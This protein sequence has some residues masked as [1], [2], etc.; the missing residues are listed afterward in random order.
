MRM[1]LLL[2]GCFESF[3]TLAIFFPK[4]D[5]STV[6]DES[7]MLNHLLLNGADRTYET[8]KE[9][10]FSISIDVVLFCLALSSLTQVADNS[11]DLPDANVLIQISYHGSSRRQEAQRLGRISRAKKVCYLCEKFCICDLI[12]V[13]SCMGSLCREDDLGRISS[14]RFSTVLCLRCD[15][16]RNNNNYNN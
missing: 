5:Y 11:F 8:L 4:K 16:L 3:L 14:M 7:E 10:L 2:V 12:F 6:Q 15:G 9:F 1:F 13:Y